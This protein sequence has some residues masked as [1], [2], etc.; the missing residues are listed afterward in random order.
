MKGKECIEVAH[1]RENT[2]NK[3]HTKK[4]IGKDPKPEPLEIGKIEHNKV[5]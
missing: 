1:S 5:I 2:S 3:G 4:A